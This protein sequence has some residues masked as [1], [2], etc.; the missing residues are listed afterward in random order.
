MPSKLRSVFKDKSGISMIFVLCVMM[1]LLMIGTSALVAGSTAA[2]AGF[3]QRTFNQLN[4]FSDSVHRTFLSSLKANTDADGNNSLGKQLMLAIYRSTKDSTIDLPNQLTTQITGVATGGG[5]RVESP[6][7]LSIT[8][9]SSIV[10]HVLPVHDDLN[11]NGIVD[12]G[13]MIDGEP[14]RVFINASM[15]VQVSVTMSGRRLTS[16]ATYEITGGEVQL[17]YDASGTPTGNPVI[18]DAGEW[19]LVA[20]EKLDR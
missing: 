20:Y 9:H 12:S 5:L 8:N 17:G 10:P 19:R 15:V 14:E 16:V 7:L 13:E 18:T 6:L 1:L 11:G 3:S 2:G 4:I